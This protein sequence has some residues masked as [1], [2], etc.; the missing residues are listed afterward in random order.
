MLK[1]HKVYRMFLRARTTLLG[2][3]VLAAIVCVVIFGPTLLREKTG[4]IFVESP[5]VF[6][7]ERLVNDRLA[8]RAWLNEQLMLTH[9]DRSGRPGNLNRDLF[10]LSDFEESRA[11][12]LL[13]GLS[14]RSAGQ[15]GTLPKLAK[16]PDTEKKTGGNQEFGHPES[17]GLKDWSSGKVFKAMLEYRESVRNELTRAQLDDRHDINGNTLLQLSFNVGIMSPSVVNTLAVVDIAIRNGTNEEGYRDL[18]EAWIN[19]IME[20][21]TLSVE[22][23]RAKLIGQETL[24]RFGGRDTRKIEQNQ[25]IENTIEALSRDYLFRSLLERDLPVSMY[26]S[27]EKGGVEVD[28]SNALS[29]ARTRQ[30]LLRTVSDFEIV[31]NQSRRELS[32]HRLCKWI[33][34]DPNRRQLWI[35]HVGSENTDPCGSVYRGAEKDVFV[36]VFRPRQ[37]GA[38]RQRGGSP[39]RT[40]QPGERDTEPPQG[41]GMGEKNATRPS[42][43]GQS[44]DDGRMPGKSNPGN[45]NER[46]QVLLNKNLAKLYAFGEV[47]RNMCAQLEGADFSESRTDFVVRLKIPPAEMATSASNIGIASNDN[48]TPSGNTINPGIGSNSSTN[49]GEH[50]FTCPSK[51]THIAIRMKILSQL[52]GWRNLWARKYGL[53]VTQI[54]SKGRNAGDGS[55]NPHRKT[56]QDNWAVFRKLEYGKSLVDPNVFNICRRL[57]HTIQPVENGKVDESI[58]SEFL[59][60]CNTEGPIKPALADQLVVSYTISEL[61]R[62]GLEKFAKLGATGCG[63]GS[64]QIAVNRLALSDAQKKQECELQQL[65]GSRLGVTIGSSTCDD[66]TEWSKFT[67]VDRFRRLLDHDAEIFSSSNSQSFSS[68]GKVLTSL[69]AESDLGV[70]AEGSRGAFEANVS[71]GEDARRKENKVVASVISYGH[72]LHRLTSTEPP[73]RNPGRSISQSSVAAHSKSASFGWIIVPSTY[74]AEDG[75]MSE[76]LR[77]LVLPTLISIPSWWTTARV[78]VSTCWLRPDSI[79]DSMRLSLGSRDH[80]ELSDNCRKQHYYDPYLVRLPWTAEE[81]SQ[82][83]RIE[84]IKEPYLKSIGI[85][86]AESAFLMVGRAGVLLIQGQRLWR[87]PRVYVGNQE[88][89]SIEVLPD[90]SGL[91]ARFSCFETPMEI[92][93]RNESTKTNESGRPTSGT[94]VTMKVWTS[95]GNTEV[96]AVNVLKFVQRNDDDKPCYERVVAG[97]P[98][99]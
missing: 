84:V 38:D 77:Q 66:E 56:I 49:S 8:Q 10:R 78:E 41:L 29:V 25:L 4:L 6:T 43:S 1:P 26:R 68:F 72:G 93:R 76:H 63:Y 53:P 99:Q 86:G 55:E 34:E 74:L 96:L 19:H 82:K 60:L 39:E 44:G 51:P 35:A 17:P 9:M 71:A 31:Y 65:D 67:V 83:L 85:A 54:D 92:A 28:R 32:F 36:R 95:E 47:A 16:K 94:P 57:A 33:R 58:F 75:D 73:G 20:L 11:R 27:D 90:M 69:S 24:V 59:E 62:H 14:A 23:R 15:S 79:K 3:F 42:V 30:I 88:A 87:N 80:E 98:D 61:R 48:T 89:D 5:R 97:A 2:V 21:A 13:V 52:V 7:R 45:N 91:I 22:S 18:Y 50:F 37:S 40:P 81:V 46:R 70:T 64:C 12:K